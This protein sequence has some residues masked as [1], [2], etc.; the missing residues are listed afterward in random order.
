MTIGVSYFGNRILRHVSA[1]MEALAARGFTGVLH[2]MSENDLA[3]YRETMGRMVA[4]SKAAGLE[5]AVGAWGLGRVFGGEAESNVSAIW[6]ET[7]Q[8]LDDGSP[9]G[10]ACPNSEAFRAFARSWADAAVETGA[11]SIFW[12]EPHWVFPGHFRRDERRWGC[13]CT[14]CLTRYAARFGEAMPTELTEEVLAFREACLV[15]FLG[16]LVAHVKEAGARSTVCLLPLVDGPHGT[17]DWEAVARLPGLDTLATDPYWQAFGRPVDEFVRSH[18]DRL[19][20]L[21]ARHGVGAQLWIQGF[22]LGPEDGEAIATAVD[23]AR[24]A[25]VTDLWTWGYEACGHMSYLATRSPEQVWETLCAALLGAPP[26]EPGTGR[27]GHRVTPG[28]IA[29]DLITPGLITEKQRSDLDDLDLRPTVEIVRLLIEAEGRVAPAVAKAVPEITVAAEEIAGRLS[30]GGRLIYV[31]AGSA[32]RLGVLDAAECG[33]TF[34]TRGEVLAL[35]A[36]GTA[37]VT[38]PSEG[39]EDDD[40]EGARAL[41]AL[42]PSPRDVVVGVSASGRTPYVLGAVR[43]GRAAGAFT[44]GVSCQPSSALSAA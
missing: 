25:G 35:I 13:R 30:V 32:G 41:S 15:E 17:A 31:G 28:P 11:D 6:P 21:A 37:A 14:A 8:I 12:D 18:A 10:A 34:G 2:T 27:P 43:A 22:R 23:V 36:G 39:A 42:T 16:Q 19:T 5:V 20:S 33:P 26:E 3:Y 9:T 40:E 4:A 44:I 1:D 38:S 29:A 7:A 24:S